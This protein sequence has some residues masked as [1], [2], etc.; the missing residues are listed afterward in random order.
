MPGP[1]QPGQPGVPGQPVMPGMQGQ[2]GQPGVPGQPVMPGMPGQPGQPGV[3]GQPPKGPPPGID[4]GKFQ[5]FTG[6]GNIDAFFQKLAT[7]DLSTLASQITTD[8]LTQIQGQFGSDPKFQEFIKTGQIP[9]MGPPPGVPG[10]TAGMPGGQPGVPGQSGQPSMPGMPVMPVMPG[11]PGQPGV[12]GQPPKGPPPGID[13]GKFQQFTGAPSIDNFFV[14]LKGEDLPTLASQIT[15]QQ[16]TEIQVRFGGDPKFQ[17]FLQTGQ[18]PEVSVVGTP[19]GAVS[20]GAAG[21][22]PAV[23]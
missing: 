13:S 20:G 14:R 18:I 8:Q 6:A 1:G 2:P 17:Q 16:L 4:S 3:P 22:A 7:E 19:T 5:Q 10:V 9:K 12:P 15:P 21:A 11:Q 23:I